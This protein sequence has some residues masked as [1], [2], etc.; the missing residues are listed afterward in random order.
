MEFKLENCKM[1]T[2]NQLLFILLVVLASCNAGNYMN[3]DGKDWQNPQMIGENKIPGRATSFPFEDKS[4]ALGFDKTRSGNF[5]SLNGLWKF[6]WSPDHTK[7]PAGFFNADFSDDQWDE[8][9]VPSN[10]QLEGYGIPIYT[11]IKGPFPPEPPYIKMDNPVGAYRTFFEIPENWDEKEVI[12]HFA[13]VQSAFYLWVNG[14]KVGYSQGSMTPSE[15]NI[16][17]YLKK[18][19]KNLLAAK[20]YRWSD[21]SYLEDIDY[22]RMSGIFRDVFLIASHRVH[23][24]DYF[25]TQTLDD[26]YQN[27]IFSLEADV[28]NLKDEDVSDITVGYEISDESDNVLL[29]DS[30]SIGK[31]ITPGEKEEIA[32]PEKMIEN[33]KKWSAEFPNLYNLTIQIK[34]H[35][36]DVIEAHATKIGF[37]KTEIIN[38]QFCV[39]GKAVDINGVNR[40]EFDP[41]RGR[42]ISEELMVQDIKLMKQ[43]NIN[44]VRTSH[45][46]NTPLWYKLCDEY[47]LYVWDETNIEGHE[48]RTTGK[49]NDDLAWK[50]A[51]VD[52]GMSMVERDKNHPSV[53]V[54][55][56][57]NEAGYGQNF[58]SLAVRIRKR[59]NSRLLH[60]EDSKESYDTP[61]KFDIIANMY[62][63]P[64]QIVDFH[65]KNPDRPVILC[66][67]SHA[68]GNNGGIMDYWNVINQYPRLQGGFIWDWVDQGLRQKTEDG[69]EYF[70]YGG[71]FG[72]EPNDANFCLNGLVYPDR[73]VSPSLIETKYAYQNVLLEPVD[74]SLNNIQIQIKNTHAFTNLNQYEVEWKISSQGKTI[75]RGNLHPIDLEPEEE[76]VVSIDPGQIQV[77][78]GQEYFVTLLFKLAEDTPWAKEGHVVAHQ[79]YVIGEQVETSLAGIESIEPINHE[80]TDDEVVLNGDNFSLIFDKKTGSITSYKKKGETLI[81]KGPEV[82]FW[83]APTDNDESD[84]SALQKWKQHGLDSLSEELI[85]FNYSME[86]N[87]AVL[88]SR[89]VLLNKHQDIKFEVTYNYTVLGNGDVIVTS[90]VNPAPEVET[91][92]KVGLQMHV[93]KVLDNVTWYG[94]GPHETYPDRKWS[95]L[96]DMYQKT[97][98]ELFEPYIKPQENGNR[99]DVRWVTFNNPGNKEKGLLFEGNELINFSARHYEDNDMFLARHLHD[100]EEKDYTIVNIDHLQAGLGTAACGP[101]LP[102]KYILPAKAYEFTIR[103]SPDIDNKN[104]R[105]DLPDIQRD[106]LS[107]PTI[108]PEKEL[109]HET[110]NVEIS[111]DN[112]DATIRYT[113]DGSIP[114]TNSK[115]YTGPFETDQSITVNAIAVDENGTSSFVNQ[116]R[117]SR[118]KYN[119]TLANA[120]LRTY[121]K[122]GID[123]LFDDEKGE[124]GKP[125]LGWIAFNEDFIATIKLPEITN[126]SR[127]ML[128]STSDW[129]WGYL[130]PEKVV[131]E[132]SEDGEN[133]TKVFEESTNKDEKQ[134]YWATREFEAE[135]DE[136]EITHVRVS[137]LNAGEVPEWYRQEGEKPVML[138]DELVIE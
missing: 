87:R 90:H 81:E 34:D 63:S 16:T 47:G 41:D 120:P 2:A 55:S 126:L 10:W 18:G 74:L 37:R 135:I 50:D 5:K 38:G 6:H 129:Y 36:G 78:P 124:P 35:E 1:K 14:E 89:K 101:G 123:D 93:S 8:I 58:D 86:E 11:N 131:F 71:D 83:R 75:N 117:Y 53:V 46:P 32:F 88:T 109:F 33:V 76:K 28:V 9:N 82:N 97:V 92:A 73:R 127:I 114:N 111:T 130:F 80:E 45:Y 108:Q 59:D 94:P 104:I 56:M 134:E 66:E 99:V 133:F 102:S 103:I 29:A 22:W 52:R 79:Q 125:E 31:S 30:K 39:N 57:G 68:M 138:F 25:V 3:D 27:G 17:D 77:Q 107:K 12:L 67:Y 137:A 48:F 7:V 42:V 115:K 105:Y 95:G 40:H 21:G 128:R 43:H 91:L 23:M 60:Y 84:Q 70:A 106:L 44:A 65:E 13:G 26:N 51:I 85:H 24:Y 54:W 132:V 15:F 64:G 110:V 72:D 113:T 69:E 136:T 112:E 49:L 20:V 119:Y 96:V 118:T 100:L 61:S 122:P 116:K 19:E 121:R 62:A 98:D 4:T